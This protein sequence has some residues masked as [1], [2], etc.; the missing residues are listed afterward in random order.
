[1]GL[2]GCFTRGVARRLALPRAI[3]FRPFRASDF[4]PMISTDQL[5]FPPSDFRPLTSDFAL[6]PQ[7][8]GVVQRIV[9]LACWID[10][11]GVFVHAVTPHRNHG[12]APRAKGQLLAQLVP[13][14]C[15]LYLFKLKD[16]GIMFYYGRTVRRL[17]GPA[18]SPGPGRPRSFCDGG[19][20]G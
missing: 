15:V 17:A 13:P 14:G 18:Q 2:S 8:D 16:E 7:C 4:S 20:G 11:K 10:A 19:L 6:S 5:R 12:R 1:M 3:I 9:L